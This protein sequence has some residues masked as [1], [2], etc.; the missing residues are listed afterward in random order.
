MMESLRKLN[1]FENCDKCKL[2][3]THD[4]G[5]YIELFKS[6]SISSNRLYMIDLASSLSNLS[7]KFG[8]N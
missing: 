5:F 7:R 3:K 6:S 4:L 1:E 2:I 8:T